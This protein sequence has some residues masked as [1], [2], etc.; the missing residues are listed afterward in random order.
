MGC[1]AARLT[2]SSAPHGNWQ[3]PLFKDKLDIWIYMHSHKHKQIA[4][5]ALP[6]WLVSCLALYIIAKTVLICVLLSHQLTTLC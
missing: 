1:H 2:F 3:E 5:P 6:L 4:N